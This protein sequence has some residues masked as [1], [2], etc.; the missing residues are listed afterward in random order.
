MKLSGAITLRTKVLVITNQQSPDSG[1]FVG[2][3][4][5]CNTR[6]FSCPNIKEWKS[7]L[8][9]WD[10]YRGTLYVCMLNVYIIYQHIVYRK[11]GKIHWAKLLHFSQFSGV[12]R[13]YFHEYKRLSLIVLNNEY[14]WIR[15]R[16]SISVKTSMA[17]KP[18]KFSPVN[19]F[20]SM[21]FQMLK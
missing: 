5:Q 21:V 20:P 7:N 17:L 13:K 3:K 11:Q 9:T 19:L 10:Y 18:W 4:F 16:K 15:Q 2:R 8:A 14:L 1:D 6:P 12:P